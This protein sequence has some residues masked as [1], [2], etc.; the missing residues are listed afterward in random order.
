MRN[1]F[2]VRIW[3][4]LAALVLANVLVPV[5]IVYAETEYL[6]IE[7]EEVAL[8]T[9]ESEEGGNIAIILAGVSCLMT[10][11]AAFVW[12]KSERKRVVDEEE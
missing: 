5:D 8:G 6:V 4:F 3:A 10:I 2:A 1:K 12:L 7:D 11:G 9:M